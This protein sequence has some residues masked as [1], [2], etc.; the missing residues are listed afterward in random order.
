M[1]SPWSQ[2]HGLWALRIHEVAS[3]HR[4]TIV[5]YVGLA[6][7][8]NFP[9]EPLLDCPVVFVLI[10]L[11]TQHS[12]TVQTLPAPADRFQ[13]ES[14]SLT[15]AVWC[16]PVFATPAKK[17]F[18][19]TTYNTRKN[20]TTTIEASPCFNLQYLFLFPK[21]WTFKQA[22]QQ[23]TLT[24]QETQTTSSCPSPA[25][26]YLSM[27]VVDL[28]DSSWKRPFLPQILGTLDLRSQWLIALCH[29]VRC[30]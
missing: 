18:Q 27:H 14:C 7:H 25:D 12:V 15:L 10:P 29:D 1:V 8:D 4:K 23:K 3:T 26:P 22:R 16:L 2:H 9:T 11:Q 5:V 21:T 28:Q 13:F 20:K 24:K 17:M 6:W 30:H 19:S